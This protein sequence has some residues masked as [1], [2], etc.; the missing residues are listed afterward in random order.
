MMKKKGG[1]EDE[2]KEKKEKQKLNPFTSM[3]QIFTPELMSPLF[4][5]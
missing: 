3:E 4:R 1:W 5:H 2:Q